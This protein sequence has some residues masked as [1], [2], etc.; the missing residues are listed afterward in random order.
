ML[1][2]SGSAARGKVEWHPWALHP[3]QV[4]QSEKTQ[5]CKCFCSVSAKGAL[6]VIAFVIDQSIIGLNSLTFWSV[7]GESIYITA[8]SHITAI[9]TLAA[10]K[11]APHLSALFIGRICSLV[12]G[13][14]LAEVPE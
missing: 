10:L 3:P 1:E 14:D 2:A 12:L 13:E 8:S 11:M 4:T 6:D 5:G 7:L 9:I